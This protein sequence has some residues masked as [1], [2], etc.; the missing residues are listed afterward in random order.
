MLE[1][2]KY[3]DIEQAKDLLSRYL[4]EKSAD[5]K[6][7]LVVFLSRFSDKQQEL[8]W[9]VLHKTISREEFER[10]KI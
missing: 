7:E 6:S 5:N 9:R 4:E 3:A 2:V 10:E 8:I 1:T